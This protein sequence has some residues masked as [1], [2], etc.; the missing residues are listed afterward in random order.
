[1]FNNSKSYIVTGNPWTTNENHAN[2]IRVVTKCLQD[3]KINKHLSHSKFVAA[4]QPVV[5]LIGFLDEVEQWTDEQLQDFIKANPVNENG[6]D[7]E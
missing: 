6:E 5:N 2:A 3:S 4:L 7:I 1:M